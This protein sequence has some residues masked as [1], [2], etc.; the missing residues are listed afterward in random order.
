M[1]QQALPEGATRRR[2]A[3][4]LFDADGWTW[5]GLKATFWFLFIIFML[6]VVP[7]WAYYITTSNT[8]QVGYNFAS[9]V[10]LCPAD[11]EDLP[12]PAPAGAMKP[13][14]AS[15]PELA[16]PAARSGS[17]VYQSGATVYLLGGTVDG[18]PS[19]E[20]LVTRV[21]EDGNLEP[22]SVGS[23]LPEPRANAS[24]GLFAGVPYLIGGFDADGVPTSTVYRGTVEEGVLTGWELSDGENRTVDLTLPQPLAGAGVVNGTAGFVLVGGTGAD[25]APTNGVYL[26]WTDEGGQELQP[27]EPLENLALPE[28]RSDV[29]A[30]G[31]GDFI[32]VIGGHGPDGPTDTVF[33]LFLQ[34]GEPETDEA[35]NLVGWAVAPEAE[36]L[37]GARADATTFTANGAIHVIGGF[38]A[39]GVPADSMLWAVPD[40]TT[41]DYEG[42]QRLEQTDLPVATASAPIVGVGPHAFVFGGETPEGATDGSLRAEI[43]P[44][45]PFFQLGIAGATIPGLS[46]KGEV[47]QQLGYMNAMGV[48]IANFIIL[49]IIGIAFSRPESSKRVI[50]RILRIKPEPEE[51]Y[52]A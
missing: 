45:P 20:V 18:S 19:D 50:G 32:Y 1:A 8:I 23:P 30:A 38:D 47:G 44:R 29:V 51:R 26:S 10:N 15:P 21:T 2:A 13:W 9:I 43:S 33:R 49:I 3:L 4:G 27:W 6:A 41:G 28:D 17:A 52:K 48:G 12:C 34:G 5:A 25:G 7:N 11:N 14:Q 22:W 36:A 40:P 37:P 24:V 46:I 35:G 39:E 31:I 16:M 42:W